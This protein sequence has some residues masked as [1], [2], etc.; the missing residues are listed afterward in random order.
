[1]SMRLQEVHPALV[2]FPITLLP[3]ALAADALGLATGSR[4]LMELGRRTIPLAAASA[5][6]AGVFG[7]VAQQAVQLDDETTDLVITHRNLNLGAIALTAGMAVSRSRA[8]KPSLGYL[9]AGLAGLGT[10]M[11]SAYLGGHM[12]YEHGVGVQKAG[13]LNEEM[14]PH[15]VPES[16]GEATRLTARHIRDGATIAAQELG[17]GKLAPAMLRP[18]THQH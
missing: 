10:V 9:A 13:G 1:M 17:E 14:A 18:D 7:L 2:H 5:A 15:L 16:A 12:V 11:Y 3:A 6:V 4:T 8:E